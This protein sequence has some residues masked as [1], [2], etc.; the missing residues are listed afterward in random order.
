MPPHLTFDKNMTSQSLA[1]I[2]LPIF[3]ILWIAFYIFWRRSRWG[4][5][6]WA[7][8]TIT[9]GLIVLY[10]ISQFLSI[11][12][13]GGEAEGWFAFRVMLGLIVAIPAAIIFVISVTIRPDPSAF[14]SSAV[15]FTVILYLII[16][17]CVS[18]PSVITY[19]NRLCTLR[20][21]FSDESGLPLS[22]IT[23]VL[24]D[25][26]WQVSDE[27]GMVEITGSRAK[28]FGG[29]FSSDR[30]SYRTK[31]VN[32]VYSF[33]DA[34]SED[35]LAVYHIDEGRSSRTVRQSY[36]LQEK[37]ADVHIILEKEK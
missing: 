23:V 34:D 28:S 10:W 24:R 11:R 15:V 30:T 27:K 18:A 36:K 29:Q 33:Q 4:L 25:Y 1:I 32:F 6:A 21:H 2:F 14:H 13:G 22:G 12:S 19:Q 9:S 31:L 16:L 7:P 35:F 20:L 5:L 37:I 17:V 26:P 8:L 3:L